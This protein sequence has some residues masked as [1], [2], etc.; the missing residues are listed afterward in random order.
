MRVTQKIPV[1]LSQCQISRNNPVKKGHFWPNS[2]TSPMLSNTKSAFFLSVCVDSCDSIRRL[3][4]S[5]ESPSL[6]ATRSTLTSIG[7]I[8][9]QDCIEVLVHAALVY[10]SRFD[11]DVRF[12]PYPRV[13]IR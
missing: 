3:I 4:W 11:E 2:V 5:T 13:P 6:L 1:T 10:E 9:Q 8:D 7:R 12:P